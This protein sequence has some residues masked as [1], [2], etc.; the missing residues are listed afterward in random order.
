MQQHVLD[1]IRDVVDWAEAS[2]A[3]YNVGMMLVAG[4]IQVRFEVKLRARLPTRLDMGMTRNHATSFTFHRDS[5]R[6]LCLLRKSILRPG[7]TNKCI[8]VSCG[9]TPPEVGDQ[10]LIPPM[11]QHVLGRIL[12]APMLGTTPVMA[13]VRVQLIPALVPYDVMHSAGQINGCI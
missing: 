1:R 7:G 10:P 8:I 4:G 12:I 11:Q 2:V 3:C 6:V 5:K 13:F 9:T